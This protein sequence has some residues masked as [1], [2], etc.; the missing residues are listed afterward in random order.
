[1]P[2]LNSFHWFSSCLHE[3]FCWTGLCLKRRLLLL[4]LNCEAQRVSFRLS[5]F[6]STN[7]IFVSNYNEVKIL[8][9]TL[10]ILPFPSH[11]LRVSQ[12][13]QHHQETTELGCLLPDHPDLCTT[14]ARTE[15]RKEI[16]EPY[17]MFCSRALWAQFNCMYSTHQSKAKVKM[18][19]LSENL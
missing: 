11:T 1:M 3:A 2:G 17:E 9:Y 7:V 6:K 8:Q 16:P 15:E 5:V 18:V 12:S 4:F 13:T 19:L 10:D 14:G